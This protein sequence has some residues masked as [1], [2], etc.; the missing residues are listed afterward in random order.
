MF[1]ITAPGGRA[2]V[3]TGAGVV[4]GALVAGALVTGALVTGAAVVTAGMAG[5][6]L[7]WSEGH[8][9]VTWSSVLGQ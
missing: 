6:V 4:T 8:P 2:V 3:V 5:T 7:S 9:V 1:G